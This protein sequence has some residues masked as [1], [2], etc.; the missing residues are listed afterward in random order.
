MSHAALTT[1]AVAMSALGQT[2]QS[3]LLIQQQRQS[4]QEQRTDDTLLRTLSSVHGRSQSGV[5]GEAS[6]RARTIHRS[7]ESARR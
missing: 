3:G 5:G 2:D 6:G 1:A 7:C 4:K